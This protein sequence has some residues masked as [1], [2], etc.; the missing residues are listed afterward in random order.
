MKVL[1][2]AIRSVGLIFFFGV[3]GL[4]QVR[5]RIL[6]WPPIPSGRITSAQ[7]DKLSTVEEAVQISDIRVEGHSI[8][9]GQTFTAD[10]DWLRTLTIRLKNV[11]GLRIIAAR[12]HIG[13]PETR[14]SERFIGTTLEYGKA[15]RVGI[16][17]EERPVVMPNEEFE[18]KFSDLQY[19]SKLQFF[20][21]HAGT[22]QFS[23]VW[24]A[25]TLIKFED[26]TLWGSG[27]LR[28]INPK[29]SCTPPGN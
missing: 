15:L 23:K 4:G 27:C 21:K 7:E 17:S 10:D 5:D 12:I 28:A 16:P 11:S 22:A 3:T 26:G 18:M 1:V 19:Q 24:I 20:A 2:L 6:T 29:S 14:D 25:Q 13:F 9:L 8:T